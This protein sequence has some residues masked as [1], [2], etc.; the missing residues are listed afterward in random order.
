MARGQG[1]QRTIPVTRD[2]QRG[3]KWRTKGAFALI[4]FVLQES[5]R[6]DHFF[7]SSAINSAFDQRAECFSLVTLL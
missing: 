4:V 5:G 7:Y 6:D 2:V 1:E 3:D